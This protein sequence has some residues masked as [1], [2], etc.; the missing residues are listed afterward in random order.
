MVKT[1]AVR[2]P[3]DLQG[4][5]GRECPNQD[6]CKYFKVKFGTGLPTSQCVC[7]YCRHTGEQNEFFTKEQIEYAESVAAKEFLGPLLR[8][9]DRSFKRLEDST[10]GG[11]IQIK[12]SSKTVHFPLKHYQERH[13]ETQ[14]TC[15]SCGL[16]FAIY[17]VFATCPDC[18]RPNA[19]LIFAKSIEVAKKRLDLI[20]S[21]DETDSELKE[22]IL[23]DALSGGISCFDAFGKALRSSYPNL[24]PEDPRNLFQNL[25]ALSQALQKSLSQS[26]ADIVGENE[27]VSLNL[28][29]QIRHICEHNM[30]VV[31]DDF[32][33]KVPKSQHLKGRKYPLDKNAIKGFLDLLYQLGKEI[34]IRLSKP[35]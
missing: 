7:P 28:F 20:E 25:N 8:D 6:C 9:L 27:A 31:D 17:G 26:L 24:L 30:G 1:I 15:D 32:V 33:K 12:V 22:A 29:F 2:F 16:E 11:M 35:E 3:T 13:L 10:R 19:T 5:T 34:E 23:T 4:L 18:G 21:L 14:V